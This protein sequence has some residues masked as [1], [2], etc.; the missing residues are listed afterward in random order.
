MATGSAVAVV[1]I[2]ALL[3]V[4][5]FSHYHRKEAQ[6]G[7]STVLLER[8]MSPGHRL[9]SQEAGRTLPSNAP[10]IRQ[11]DAL[12]TRVSNRYRM[13]I[14][15]VAELALTSRNAIA[16]ESPEDVLDVLDAALFATEGMP[17]A[18]IPPLAPVFAAYIKARLG[19]ASVQ[20]AHAITRSFAEVA[21]DQAGTR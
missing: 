20:D 12:L 17:Q 10:R 16:K 15:K 6:S 5:A 14:A 18:S 21:A 7:E 9:L 3:V 13:S 19:G 11:A 4:L 2:A 8:G 1:V